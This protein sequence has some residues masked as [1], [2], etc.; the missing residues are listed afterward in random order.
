MK[1]S[2][3]RWF[4]AILHNEP[5]FNYI[6]RVS[7]NGCNH[8]SQTSCYDGPPVGNMTQLIREK[9][10]KSRISTEKRYC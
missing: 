9:D 10:N 5:G 8:A 2:F 7:H 6:S 4:Q 1:N 3:V